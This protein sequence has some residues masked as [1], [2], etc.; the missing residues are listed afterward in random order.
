ML[1][2][3]GTHRGRNAAGMRHPRESPFG[4]SRPSP[5]VELMVTPK[6]PLPGPEEAYRIRPTTSQQLSQPGRYNE[7][8]G[9]LTIQGAAR[10]TFCHRE[11]GSSLLVTLNILSVMVLLSTTGS[12]G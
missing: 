2:V 12:T 9:H 7:I 3:I 11:A 6:T 4:M 8:L 1:T 10:R 5:R